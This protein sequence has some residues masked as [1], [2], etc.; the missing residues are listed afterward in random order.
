MPQSTDL[1]QILASGASVRRQRVWFELRMMAV[2]ILI[3][4]VLQTTIYAIVLIRAARDDWHNYVLVVAVLALVP[5]VSAALLVS[6]RRQEFPITGA[7]LITINVSVFAV[8]ALSALRIPLSFTGLFAAL[9]VTVFV[10]VAANIRYR[11]AGFER[12]AVLPFATAE[13]LAATLGEN[14]RVIQSPLDDIHDVDR[15]LTDSTHHTIEWSHFL[16][17]LHML[18]VEVTPWLKYLEMRL[19]R[20]D[21]EHFDIAHLSFS[22]SQIYYVK[23]KRA[24]DIAAVIV[25]APLALLLAGAIALYIYAL[26]GGPVIFRQQRRAYGGGS[27]TMYKFRT[28]YRDAGDRA[29]QQNDPRILPGCR[30]LRQVRLD[31]LPQLYNILIG[32]MSW[33][34]PRP[35]AVPIAEICERISAQYVNRHLV[36]PGLTGWAQVSHSYASNPEEELEK[37][38]YDLYYIKEISFDLDLLILMKTVKILFLRTGAR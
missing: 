27:F 38:A 22:L 11:R 36:L 15:V 32:N 21:V 12:V 24:V 26:D 33:I 20:V 7:A 5:L 13:G 30:F 35:V 17:R 8:A 2:P 9:C 4:I 19:R 16:T 18:G 14:V 1:A 28:M 3:A 6:L 37:L 25:A 10:M 23:A 31:E 34:G 29:A